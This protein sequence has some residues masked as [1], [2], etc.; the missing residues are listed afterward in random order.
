MVC[1]QPGAPTLREGE[2]GN[3]VCKAGFSTFVLVGNG[4]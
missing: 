1:G 2:D 4:S 3:K